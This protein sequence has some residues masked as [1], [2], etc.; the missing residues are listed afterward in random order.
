MKAQ[1]TRSVLTVDVFG[2]FVKVALG[3][4]Y[5]EDAVS[6][7]FGN[8]L[9]TLIE[10]LC[11]AGC[12][13]GTQA[14]GEGVGTLTDQEFRRTIHGEAE[15]Q[16]LQVHHLSIPGNRIDEVGYMRLERVDIA[17][18]TADKVWTE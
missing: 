12:R 15:E 13:D 3:H 16:R 6:G 9:L 14:R 5:L 18:L 10:S 17:H 4:E 11:E 2:V 1:G 7:K 8:D